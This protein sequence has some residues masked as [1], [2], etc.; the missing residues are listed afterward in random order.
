MAFAFAIVLVL[1]STILILITGGGG[2][3]SL[4]RLALLITD[5]ESNTD[6]DT[7]S[8][9]ISLSAEELSLKNSAVARTGE[10]WIH[11]MESE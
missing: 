4:F 10:H 2:V 9:H 1:G 7:H 5:C 3:A 8:L 6:I 11:L